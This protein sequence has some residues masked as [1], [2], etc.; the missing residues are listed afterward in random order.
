MKRAVRWLVSALVA[1]PLSA[2]MLLG[3]CLRDACRDGDFECIDEDGDGYCAICCDMPDVP[4][5]SCELL[6]CDDG[7]A[8]VHPRAPDWYADGGDFDCDGTDLG[9]KGA[10]CEDDSQCTDSC[11]ATVSVCTPE[12]EQCG[13][14][15][16]EDGDDALDCADGDCFEACPGLLAAACDAA[17]L[18]A[19]TSEGPQ[20]IVGDDFV[21]AGNLGALSCGGQASRERHYRLPPMAGP[22]VLS[23]STSTSSLLGVGTACGVGDR[24]CQAS[25]A[26]SAVDVVVEAGDELW[27]TIEQSTESP[28]ELAWSLERATCGDGVILAPETCDDGNTQWGDGCDMECRVETSFDPCS[29]AGTLKTGVTPGHTAMGTNLLEASCGGVDGLERLHVFT[30]PSDG[31]LQVGITSEASLAVYALSGCGPSDNELA[32]VAADQAAGV[33]HVPV[34]AATLVIV[35][36]D[37][38]VPFEGAAYSLTALFTPG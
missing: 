26:Q 12:A 38:L 9:G 11:N 8:A 10:P 29:A 14:G 31:T 28:F 19:A 34:T 20:G 37:G 6:D 35:V 7:D 33:V 18:V 17:P 24:A 3:G 22:G 5:S 4:A 16:D 21:G 36:V 23:L 15:I 2:G 25:G 32:C 27:V 1:A 13:S 30:P